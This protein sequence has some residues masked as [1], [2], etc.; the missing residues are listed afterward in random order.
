M[1]EQTAPDWMGPEAQS[2]D[3][4]TQSQ[5]Y[6]LCQQVWNGEEEMF[7]CPNPE[8]AEW[9]HA[10][11]LGKTTAFMKHVVDGNTWKCPKC[12]PEEEDDDNDD[13]MGSVRS[14]TPMGQSGFAQSQRDVNNNDELSGARSY[15][16]MG[17]SGLVESQIVFNDD[18]ERT[19]SQRLHLGLQTSAMLRSNVSDCSTSDETY[20][21]E[22]SS[23]CSSSEEEDFSENDIFEEE[24]QHTICDGETITDLMSQHSIQAMD[25]T[26]ANFEDIEMREKED[27]PKIIISPVGDMGECC[28]D[29][30]SMYTKIPLHQLAV[31]LCGLQVAVDKT[32]M[33]QDYRRPVRNEMVHDYSCAIRLGQIPGHYQTT[34][35]NVGLIASSCPWSNKR[36]LKFPR[37]GRDEADS[38]GIVQMYNAAQ[39]P[40]SNYEVLLLKVC[41]FISFM[42]AFSVDNIAQN[43]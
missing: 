34:P 31:P 41:F 43:E 28:I 22:L 12:D 27:E 13:N 26:L 29:A 1:T 16:P 36:Y 14:Y 40:S 10:G 5:R 24:K 17:Q 15:T 19:C 30:L 9:Y 11:C 6:C 8:C 23:V 33:I 2:R 21:S 18:E 4:F 20:R 32:K 38:N 7:Q 42:F 3:R 39:P 35:F 37:S 25:D